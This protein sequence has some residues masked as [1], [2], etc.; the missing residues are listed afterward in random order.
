MNLFDNQEWWRGNEV[1]GND[2][3]KSLLCSIIN[4]GN[5]LQ[6]NRIQWWGGLTFIRFVKLSIVRGNAVVY[7]PLSEGKSGGGNWGGKKRGGL[8]RWA[9][10]PT[11]TPSPTGRKL[12]ALQQ[13]TVHRVIEQETTYIVFGATGNTVNYKIAKL[14]KVKKQIN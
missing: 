1:N 11:T 2:V 12:P 5:L 3:P 13:N 6:G 10:P 14:K 9:A 7:L 4:C 8:W